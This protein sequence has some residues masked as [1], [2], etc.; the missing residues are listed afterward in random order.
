MAVRSALGASR[1]RVAWL[2]VRTGLVTTAI[3]LIPGVAAAVFAGRALSSFLFGVAPA[4]P[5]TLAAA[6]GF[7]ALVAL[8]ACALPAHRAASADPMTILRRE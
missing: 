4:D 2:V 5:V 7:L 6:A 3:G 1:R 8:A